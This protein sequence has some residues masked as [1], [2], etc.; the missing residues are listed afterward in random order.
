MAYS[1]KFAT[2]LYGPFREAAG[3]APSFGNRK[4]YQFPPNARGLAKRALL[5]DASEGADILMVKPA[6]PYTDIIAEARELCPNHPLAAYQVG[7]VVLYLR[8]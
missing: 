2:S 7:H 5:R 6:M 1:A 3:S 8:K 4:C